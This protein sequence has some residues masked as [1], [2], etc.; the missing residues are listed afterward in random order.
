MSAENNPGIP[1]YAR[2]NIT[3]E[4]YVSNAIIGE[5]IKENEKLRKLVEGSI[6]VFEEIA[7][8]KGAY[9]MDRLEHASNTIRDMVEIAKNQIAKL[10]TELNK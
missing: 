5:I 2:P 1:D 4:D 6:K 10:K 3:E 8:A 9:S 7:E